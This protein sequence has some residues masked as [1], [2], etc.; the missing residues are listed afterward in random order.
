MTERTS[1]VSRGDLAFPLRMAGPDEGE[2]VLFLHGFPQTS[3]MWSPYLS[4]LASAGF[5]AV[6]PDQRGYAATAR[7][8][9]VEHYA[10]ELLVADVLGVADGLGID[11]F[12]LVGHD[13]GGAVGWALAGA[14][15][16]RLHSLTSVSTP[17]PRA[18][19]WSL[20]RS[21]QLARS[22]YIG[23]FQIPGIP[24]RILTAR[25]GRLLR[26][27]LGDS[28]LP[29]SRVDA[30]VERML[31]PGAMTAALN[32]YR[33]LRPRHAFGTGRITVP[34]LHVWSTRDL[35]LGPVAART[36]GREVDAPYRFVVLENTSHWIPETRVDE[37]STLLI[38]HIRAHG[39]S[40]AA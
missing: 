2:A 30:Y 21:S 1:Q 16:E 22:W 3:A 10:M 18:L 15:P 32:Y 8:K 28:G 12:H 40:A 29:P 38:D 6:A 39:G 5:L 27:T 24:E 26:R 19:A 31:Q 7:P 36:T 37:L 11:R 9:E 23:L 13:W 33:A 4:R 14:H 25:N 35:A 34:T 17:H 20:W